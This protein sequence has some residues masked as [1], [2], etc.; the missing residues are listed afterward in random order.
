MTE[1]KHTCG[2]CILYLPVSTKCPNQGSTAFSEGC[3]LFEYTNPM[4]RIDGLTE[5]FEASQDEVEKLR[6]LLA[7]DSCVIE[8]AKRMQY[9]LD[10]NKH[11]ECP[12]MNPDGKGRGWEKCMYT[13]LWG[14]IADEHK[15]LFD[16]L[17]EGGA[18]GRENALNECA[19][20]GNFAM[21]IHDK[22]MV[23]QSLKQKT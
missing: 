14:R 22:L 16:S 6:K 19:D 1:E 12:T 10:K 15:E 13:W 23:E 2:Q 5:E 18:S 7:M 17:K 20:I 8:Y 3:E 21:M 4:G 9:K 11:K